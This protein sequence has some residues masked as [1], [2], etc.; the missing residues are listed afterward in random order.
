MLVVTMMTSG[1]GCRHSGSGS[2]CSGSGSGSCS[3]SAG[4]GCG[5]SGGRCRSRSRRNGRNFNEYVAESYEL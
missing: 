5:G 3:G 2:C 1:L 4:G